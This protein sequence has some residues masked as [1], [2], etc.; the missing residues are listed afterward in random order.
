M[1]KIILTRERCVEHP[2]A[3][4]NTHNNKTLII[5]LWTDGGDGGRDW[6]KGGR[7]VF[8]FQTAA[9]AKQV[10]TEILVLPVLPKNK[11]LKW[12]NLASL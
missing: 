9:Q 12:K 11:I 7:A 4:Q 3:G 8:N 10:K 2:F 6:G 5:S 1:E